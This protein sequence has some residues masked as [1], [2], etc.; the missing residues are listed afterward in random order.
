MFGHT[1]ADVQNKY[2]RPLPLTTE[3]GW[4]SLIYKITYK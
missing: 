4:L 3:K 1:S 2:V